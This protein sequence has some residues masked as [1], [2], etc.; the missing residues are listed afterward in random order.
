MIVLGAG[1][2]ALEIAMQ[3]GVFEESLYFFSEN[4]FHS[5]IHPRMWL[6]HLTDCAGQ[7]GVLGVGSPKLR[8]RFFKL[9]IQHGLNMW[10]FD[11]SNISRGAVYD[12]GTTLGSGSCISPKVR[13]GKGVLVN[14][15]VTVGHDSVVG[16]FC[17]LAPGAHIS[18]NCHL[19]NRVYI[20]SGAVLREGVSVGDDAVVGAGTVV[21]KDVP[22][23]ET[24]VGVPARY[25]DTHD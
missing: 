18:G 22:A 19:G 2:F 6:T 1:G 9:A 4:A 24:W 25:L 14:Y 15:N 12:V 8:E 10:A 16:D 13:L 17:N 5:E 20:G 21:L 11:R 7:E 23:R 3:L